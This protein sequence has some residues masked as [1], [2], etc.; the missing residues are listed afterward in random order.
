MVAASSVALAFG[1]ISG[2]SSSG[3]DDTTSNAGKSGSGASGASGGSGGGAPSAGSSAKAGKGGSSSVA[4]QGSGGGSGKAGAGRGSGGGGG[5]GGAATGGSGDAAAGGDGQSGGESGTGSG[6]HDEA[7]W[8]YTSGNQILVSDG[9]GGGTPWVGRGVNVDDIFLCGYNNSLWMDDSEVVLTS[10]VGGVITDWKATFLRLSLSMASNMTTVSWFEDAAK[11]KTPVTNV[12]KSIGQHPNV[13]VLVTVRSDSSMILHDDQHGDPEATGIPSDAT[14]TPD[15]DQF[16]TG[17]DA[18][19]EALV[20]T[21]GTDK[22]VLFGLTNEPGGGVRTDEEIRKAMDH[23]VSTIRAKEDAF[24]V[25][26]HLVS[27]QG[28]GWTSN[29]STYADQ[30]LSQDNVIYEVH[31][32]PPSTASYTYGNLPVI[33]GEYGSLDS[34]SAPA[35]YADLEAKQLPNLAWDLEP[36]SPCNPDLV[37]VDYS[38]SNLTPS[39]GWGTIVKAY[40]ADHAR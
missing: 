39:E 26:H 33:L 15:K 23:A 28:N 4:G 25:P 7:G 31:G 35:F 11:Y 29:I 32:Y 27:V 24:G 16:P 13:Y 6:N 20:E 34:G 40:L 14:T 22:F 30:P 36:Y 21:F 12:I 9:H 2:C 1:A 38:P 8:L 37:E 18:L 19:Y 3:D 10:I 17:T 5:K